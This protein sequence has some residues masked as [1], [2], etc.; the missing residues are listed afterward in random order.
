LNNAL[1]NL[2]NRKCQP[3]DDPMDISGQVPAAYTED[4]RRRA[5]ETVYS[6]AKRTYNALQAENAGDAREALRLW[7]LV[8]NGNF[9]KS[10]VAAA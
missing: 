10:A 7:D 8:F 5:Q 2:A 6:S 4:K 9:P 1:V 3:L